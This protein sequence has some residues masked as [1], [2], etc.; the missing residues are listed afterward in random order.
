MMETF[1]F[2]ALNF[3]LI[4]E[5]D[6]TSGSYPSRFEAPAYQSEKRPLRP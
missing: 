1:K 4:N 2:F 3:T 5:F 6:D